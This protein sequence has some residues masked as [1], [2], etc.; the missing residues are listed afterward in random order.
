MNA[1]F[2]G[3]YRR[4]LTANNSWKFCLGLILLVLGMTGAVAS[5]VLQGARHA[6]SAH[7]ARRVGFVTNASNP[8]DGP[9]L[10]NA[11]PVK[12][13]PSAG[14]GSRGELPGTATGS[15]RIAANDVSPSMAAGPLRPT[16]QIQAAARARVNQLYNQLPLSFEANQGQTDS[17]VKFLSRGQGYSLFLTPTEAVLSVRKASRATSKQEGPLVK[18]AL[19][20]IA[21]RYAVVRIRLD[22]A[23]PDPQITGN[24]NLPGKSNYFIGNDP[25]KWRANLST[26]AKVKYRSVYPGVDLV[27]YG[28]QSRPEYDFIVAP[29]ADPKQIALT[30]AG[31]KRARLT[32]GNLVVDLG[33][34]QVIERA[35]LIYQEI[36][37]VRRPVAGGYQLRDRHTVGFKLAHYDHARPLIIDPAL[38]FS[39]Y[40]GG[41]GDDSGLGIALDSSNNAYVTGQTAAADFP[42][43]AGAFQT[44]LAGF[45][46]AFVTKLNSG[47]T[48][49]STYLGGSSADSGSASTAAS[50]IALDSSNNAYVTGNTN[51]TDFPTTA[52]AF[53]STFAGAL[54]A[55]VTKLNSSGTALLYSTYLG[56]SIDASGSPSASGSAIAL[57]SSNNAYV[58]GYT[59]CTDFPTAVGAFQ[60]TLAS[61]LDAFVTDLNSSGTAL[62]Y[63]TYLGGSGDDGANGIALDSSNNAYVTGQT[64]SADF[65]ITLGAF[66]TT[67][68]GAVDAFVTEVN[69]S[70]TALLYSTYV[71]GSGD[72][73]SYGIALD[74]SNNA[75][76][77][78]VTFSADFPTTA[79]AF[80][81]TFGG[82]GVDAFVTKLDPNGATLLY[83]T[84][85]GGSSTDLGNAIALDSSNN[86]YITGQTFSRDRRRRHPRT[87][88]RAIPYHCCSAWL[89]TRHRRR[90]ICSEKHRR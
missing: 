46:D 72:D 65:P 81:T 63:S 40:L 68:A 38:L 29:R 57:D 21:C 19:T 45:T 17:R 51:S 31:A 86:A 22:H 78:G 88:N 37:G 2:G 89:Q 44:T 47:G 23:N 30:F 56:G 3:G 8:V 55:F 39:T 6:P 71:G 5:G 25:G 12:S 18:H 69:S 28:N 77:T 48:V 62:L 75:Y 24:G 35:P 49:Y 20:G 90:Q 79:G 4:R 84:Y 7:L 42:T 26:Y 36:G 80:Q 32:R 50:A 15:V 70:G 9:D 13:F 61:T 64:F 87:W 58:T 82:G 53:Q 52:G 73:Y 59:D 67:F 85:L 83:S 54:D 27:Y 10:N 1:R 11:A 16:A 60:T 76:L 74:S 33:G 34:A 41:L 66:Q 43:T 14:R